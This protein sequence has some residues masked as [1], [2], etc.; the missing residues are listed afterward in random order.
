MWPRWNPYGGR[1]DVVSARG[2]RVQEQDCGVACR[3]HRGGSAT[4]SAVLV[5]QQA[6]QGGPGLEGDATARLAAE[7]A[8]RMGQTGRRRR[9]SGCLLVLWLACGWFPPVAAGVA[10]LPKAAVDQAHGRGHAMQD[11][12]GLLG[13]GAV[14]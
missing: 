14:E 12:P 9:R 5:R 6:P 1:P 11:R 4:L 2:H 3:K 10:G 7:I 8:I 13:R